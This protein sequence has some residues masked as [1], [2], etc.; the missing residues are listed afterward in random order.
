MASGKRELQ[1]LTQLNNEDIYG[2]FPD[3]VL[4]KKNIVRVLDSFVYQSHL[5]IV[6]ECFDMNLR[7]TL[8]KIAR[9]PV[10]LTTLQ[11]Y[12]QS[13]LK[14]LYFLKKKQLIH[15]DSNFLN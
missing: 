9:F 5:C 15:A 13:L 8:S 4:D 10:P 7:D 6:M 12:A 14:T 1:V 3:I 2:K 11:S